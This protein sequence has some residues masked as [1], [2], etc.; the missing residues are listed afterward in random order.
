[1]SIKK[2]KDLLCHLIRP[3]TVIMLKW[4]RDWSTP[5]ISWPTCWITTNKTLLAQV[6]WIGSKLRALQKVPQAW[7]AKVSFNWTLIPAEEEGLSTMRLLVTV[8]CLE[9]AR[10][11]QMVRYQRMISQWTG[12]TW[13]DLEL[14][15]SAMP[16]PI[17]EDSNQCPLFNSK[18]EKS[19]L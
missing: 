4:Q 9:L 14:I 6:V 7:A 5:K 16:I 17:Q 18:K 10:P 3:L 15:L 13:E 2:V 19:T 11:Y 8:E 1:M 12:L